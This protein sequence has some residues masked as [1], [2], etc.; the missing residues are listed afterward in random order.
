MKINQ[1]G[2]S[3]LVVM[4]GFVVLFAIGSLGYYIYH[5]KHKGPENTLSNTALGLKESGVHNGILV[6]KQATDVDTSGLS[7]AQ[8]EILKY[9]KRYRFVEIP[10]D[11]WP[12]VLNKSSVKIELFDDVIIDLNSKGPIESGASG[13][14]TW[15]GTSN[16]GDYATLTFM[17]GKT[18]GSI[19]SDKVGYYI[20]PI[21]GEKHLI[22]APGENKN[23][24]RCDEGCEG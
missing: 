24:P 16:N 20:S 15:S 5:N 13:S 6:F 9:A 12:S 11:I 17:N 19:S 14:T 18:I 1:K 23:Y 10:E 4:L 2:F 3:H 21:S 22:A 8:K 7:P